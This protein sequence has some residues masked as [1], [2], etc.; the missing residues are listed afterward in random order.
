MC[1]SNAFIFFGYGVAKG[2]ARIDVHGDLPLPAELQ[3]AADLKAMTAEPRAL[4]AAFVAV[5]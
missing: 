4:K 5:V 2:K 3:I 1:F